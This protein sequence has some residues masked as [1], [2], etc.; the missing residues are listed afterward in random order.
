M[1]VLI[2][3]RFWPLVLD[4]SFTEAASFL[5]REDSICTLHSSRSFIFLW[6]CDSINQTKYGTMLSRSDFTVILWIL[7]DCFLNLAQV[8][9]MF[10]SSGPISAGHLSI[11]LCALGSVGP[12]VL[13]VMVWTL[14]SSS[15]LRWQKYL[16]KS[17]LKMHINNN[18]NSTYSILMLVIVGYT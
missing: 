6:F 18:S 1:V 3:L 8:H 16:W 13:G 11:S 5:S 12:A 15:S 14:G 9:Q 2:L 17:W 4:D 10:I 7:L